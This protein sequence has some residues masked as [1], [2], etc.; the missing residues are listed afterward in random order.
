MRVLHL[1]VAILVLTLSLEP[2]VART[3]KAFSDVTF[4]DLYGHCKSNVD[5]ADFD[6]SPCG[7]YIHGSWAAFHVYGFYISSQ[8]AQGGAEQGSFKRISECRSGNV[9]ALNAA[10]SFN[11]F[12]ED[13][14]KLGRSPSEES[15]ASF[16]LNYFLA[17]KN[18]SQK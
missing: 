9:S 6:S 17:C 7:M 4:S 12:V 13:D 1:C 14:L 15:P 8:S 3:A 10:K 5:L 18:S 16:F 11:S 2:A